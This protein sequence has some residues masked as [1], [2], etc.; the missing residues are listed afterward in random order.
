MVLE[1]LMGPV[2]AERRPWVMIFLGF[3]YTTVALYLSNWIF[4]E[5]ASLVMVFLIAIAAAPIMYRAIKHEEKIDLIYEQEKQILLHHLKALNFMMFLFIGITA[6]YALWY[7]VLPADMTLSLF[8][9]QEETITRI[10]G[11]VTANAISG[12][13]HFSKIFFNNLRVMIFCI[14]FSLTY[15]LGAIFILVWNASVIGVALGNFIRSKLALYSSAVGLAN[16]GVY[17]KVGSWGI[18][19]YAIHGIP[20]I[21]AYFMAG[22]AGG[23]ISIAIIRHDFGTK[24]LERIL[25]DASDLLI[26]AIITLIGAAFIETYITPALF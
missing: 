22:L 9:V 13:D 3:L 7:L 10:N 21:L 18:L 25:M 26:L 17:L 23:I 1:S 16:V 2:S 14:L 15:G 8:S 5:Y 20:E 19:R 6:A 11:Q 12:F 24:K 4:R